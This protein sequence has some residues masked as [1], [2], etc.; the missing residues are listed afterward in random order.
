MRIARDG[1]WYHEG[2]P[3][4]RQ[5]MTAL[6][7]SILLLDEEGGYYLVTPLEKVRIRVD[8]CPFVVNQMEVSGSGR[9]QSIQFA[10]N[11][12][13]VV[14]LDEEHGLDIEHDP[15]SLEPH[16]VVH[17]RSGLMALLSRAVFYRLIALAEE[18]DEGRVLS[19]WSAGKQ[20]LFPVR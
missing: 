8:D 19:L 3:I 13:E 11:V 16:P 15:E 17:I 2:R 6:F 9:E 12:G 1:T 4:R 18:R 20:F 10:T 7:A 14:T 5:A